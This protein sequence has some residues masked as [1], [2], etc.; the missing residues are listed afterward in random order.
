[1]RLAGERHAGEVRSDGEV[2]LSALVPGTYAWHS[3]TGYCPD[4]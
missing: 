2:G 3:K 1:M 4:N